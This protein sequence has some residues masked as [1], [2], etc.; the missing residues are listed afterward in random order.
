MTPESVS[1]WLS[2][3]NAGGTVLVLAAI[4]VY[5]A[6]MLPEFL[7]RWGEHT[8]ALMGIKMELQAIKDDIKEM[9]DEFKHGGKDA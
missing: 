2:V 8:E 6:K 5:G 3:L 1:G 9:C 4:V 7:K